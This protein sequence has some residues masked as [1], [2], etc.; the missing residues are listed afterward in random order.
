MKHDQCFLTIASANRLPRYLVGAAAVVLASASAAQQPTDSVAPMLPGL[1]QITSKPQM[2]GLMMPAAPKV[3]KKCLSKE[4]IQQGKIP[5][6]ALPACT[7]TGGTWNGPKLTASVDCK[8]ALPPEAQTSVEVDAKETSFE[9]VI[10][11]T[12]MPNAATEPEKGR[13]NYEQTGQRLS[14]TC[15]P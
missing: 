6:H 13:I 9:G 8:H 14:D 2:G 1:W 11:V 4:T 3:E 15:T 7:V 12:L 5:M 10:R